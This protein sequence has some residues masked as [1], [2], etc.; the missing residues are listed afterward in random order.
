MKLVV[1]ALFASLF[2]INAFAEDA[3]KIPCERPDIPSRMAS[4]LV[5]KSFNKHSA[6]YK[7]C[8]SDFVNER[9]AFVDSHA[10]TDVPAAQ[11]AHDA[12]EAAIDQYNDFIKQLNERNAAAGAGGDDN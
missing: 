7:K 10:T 5:M 1:S 8:I 12:A 9:R 4:D 3:P 11:A 2:A 6:T